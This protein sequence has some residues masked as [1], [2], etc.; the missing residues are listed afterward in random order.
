MSRK[1]DRIIQTSFDV[2]QHQLFLV[3]IELNWSGESLDFLATFLVRNRYVDNWDEITIF[4]EFE[5]FYLFLD[6]GLLVDR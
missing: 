3:V 1:P 5:L 4:I 2:L 6:D